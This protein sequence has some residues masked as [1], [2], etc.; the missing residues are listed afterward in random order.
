MGLPASSIPMHQGPFLSP[1]VLILQNLAT[2]S[3][4]NSF[5]RFLTLPNRLLPLKPYI[6]LGVPLAGSEPLFLSDILCKDNVE[7]PWSPPFS[8]RFSPSP[9][10]CPCPEACSLRFFLFQWSVRLEVDSVL[11]TG[12]EDL[13]F[14]FFVPT[15]IQPQLSWEPT[16]LPPL[17]RPITARLG[18]FPHFLRLQVSDFMVF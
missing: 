13:P 10:R 12:F 17:D 11:L 8:L 4:N 1:L 2:T 16:C 9:M 5:W 6:L 18:Q 15:P 14:P 7:V 3:L